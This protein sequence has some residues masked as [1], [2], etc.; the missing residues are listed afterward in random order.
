ME[1]VKNYFKELNEQYEDYQDVKEGLRNLHS[2]GSISDAEYNYALENW[3]DL[4]VE[5]GFMEQEMLDIMKR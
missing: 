2:T 4:L 5:L 3:N 1:K